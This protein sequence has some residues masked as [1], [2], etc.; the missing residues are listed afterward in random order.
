[1]WFLPF[2]LNLKFGK[3]DFKNFSSYLSYF[4]LC[5]ICICIKIKF[6][7]TLAL[8]ATKFNP[9]TFMFIKR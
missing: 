6:M 8:S 4:C 1:M 7:S 9:Y 5:S 3:R 2:F